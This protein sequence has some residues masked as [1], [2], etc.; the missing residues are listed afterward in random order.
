MTR[1]LSHWSWCSINAKAESVSRL[2]MF[3]DAYMPITANQRRH[4]DKKGRP[5]PP[6]SGYAVMR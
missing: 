4:G 3:R 1:P 5:K 2:P 6:G